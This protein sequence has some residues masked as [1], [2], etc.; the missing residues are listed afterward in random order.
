MEVPLLIRK[1]KDIGK[2]TDGAT[3]KFPRIRTSA[4]TEDPPSK[5]NK[6]LAFCWG[7]EALIKYFK[8]FSLDIKTKLGTDFV[9]VSDTLQGKNYW[10]KKD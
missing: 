3:T 4:Y 6:F 10:R 9:V 1:A 5:Q 7:N 8:A 2:K